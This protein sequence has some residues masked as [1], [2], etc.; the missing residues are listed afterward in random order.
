MCSWCS[1]LTVFQRTFSFYHVV[2]DL[3]KN[4]EMDII[5]G[6]MPGFYVGRDSKHKHSNI[7]ENVGMF[8]LFVIASLVNYIT[9]RTPFFC[10]FLGNNR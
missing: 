2:A 9:S 3:V 5:G 1:E 6:A 7:L 4:F 8:V 10:S